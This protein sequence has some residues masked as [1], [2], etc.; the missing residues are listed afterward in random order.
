MKPKITTTIAALVFVTAPLSNAADALWP[1]FTDITE[2]AGIKFKHNIGDFEM[3]NIVEATGP[4]C[5]VFDYDNDGFMD[6]YFVNG[7]WHPDISD[8]RGRR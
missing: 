1:K 3:S 7:R 2:A 8:N 6:I 5:C 4:G